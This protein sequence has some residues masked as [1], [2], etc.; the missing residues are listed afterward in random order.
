MSW[1]RVEPDAPLHP[2][3]FRGGVAAFGFDVAGTA[4][5][6]RNLTDGFIPASDLGLIH[7]G[8]PMPTARKLADTLVRIGRWESADGG[9]RVHDYARYQPTKEDVDEERRRQHDKSVAGGRA[10]A[11]V[12]QRI[13][14]RFV[15]QG[16]P[17]TAPANHQPPAGNGLVPAHQPETSLVSSRL[18]SSQESTSTTLSGERPTKRVN[19]ELRAAS[20]DVLRWLNDKAGKNFPPDS[21]NLGLIEAR[22]REGCQPWQLKKIVSLKVKAWGADPERRQ[23]LRPATLFGKQKCSQYIGE[24][25]AGTEA[26][27]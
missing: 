18:V 4:Y 12:A 27:E 23:Y 13:R 21:T 26:D 3:H 25:P 5:C 10:R 2:K 24:I 14:G 22:L 19:A 11:G 9:W 17:A 15:A 8:T 16:S 20:N 6:L 1:V 7:P